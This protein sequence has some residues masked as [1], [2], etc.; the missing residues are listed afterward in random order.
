MFPFF[1]TVILSINIAQE[2]PS[3][4]D[5]EENPKEQQST[6]KNDKKKPKGNSPPKAPPPPPK[7]DNGKKKN[8]KPNIST[9]ESTNSTGTIEIKPISNEQN[10]APE[11]QNVAPEIIE[12]IQPPTT[13]ELLLQVDRSKFD[14]PITFNSEVEYWVEY[15]SSN[16]RWT[17]SK[18]IKASGKY[19][20]MIQNELRKAGLPRDLLYVAMI[21]SGFSTTAKSSA[22]AMGVWQFIPT[23][24]RSYGLLINET[25]D[26]RKAPFRAT[27]AAIAYLS[28]LHREFGNWYL[29]MAAYNSGSGRV[30]QAMN[31]H[32][33]IN[34]WDLCDYDALPG[35]TMDYVPRVIAAAILDKYPRLFGIPS[36]GKSKAID[37]RVVFADR[38]QHVHTLAEA[39]EM[40][41]DEFAKYNPHIL[42]D[43]IL[44]EEAE[45]AIYLPPK[46]VEIYEQNIR[47]LGVNRISSG[48]TMTDEEIA[49]LPEKERIDKSS[50]QKS[51]SH[52]VLEDE[53]IES[54]AK[55][56]NIDVN[57]LK[58]WNNIDKIKIGQTLTLQ[59]PNQKRLE[60]YTVKSGDSLK[61]IAKK[62]NC[63]TEDIRNWNALDEDAK[64]RSGDVLWIKV[65]SN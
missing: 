30:S 11:T 19:R 7:D 54:I 1:L 57:D 13:Q 43:R 59:K 3:S 65:S 36:S 46:K 50:H 49:A 12:V 48:R 45:I 28:K 60:R 2:P 29:A 41:L 24:G 55:R 63:T 22:S 25:I 51:F 61:K 6:K 4:G 23:T 8:Q 56:Y 14:I 18:W 20:N 58:V 27:Q 33:T 31:K 26:E 47:R 17:M 35:E 21:E 38:N 64:V 37:I 16:G 15:F 9:T 40:D 34:F 62:Y 5:S 52:V 32:G 53:T 10:V 39:A 42:A 44:I